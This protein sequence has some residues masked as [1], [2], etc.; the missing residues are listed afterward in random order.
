[1][2]FLNPFLY[3][4]S[5]SFTTDI[6]TGN[7]RCLEQSGCSCCSEGYYAS[8]GWDPVSG[9]GLV[10]FQ[11]FSAKALLVE[12][13]YPSQSPTLRPTFS[14]T[15]TPTLSPTYTPGAPTPIPTSAPSSAPTLLPT[16]N[17][18]QN[19]T[20]ETFQYALI[21]Q[22][23]DETCY[24]DVE[25]QTGYIANACIPDGNSSFILSCTPQDISFQ[26][27]ESS[28]D[29]TGVS[30]SGTIP[31]SNCLKG[32]NAWFCKNVESYYDLILMNSGNL[33]VTTTT[34]VTNTNTNL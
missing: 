17:P 11:L 27:Y 21:N 6:T 31:T 24:G 16:P 23:T 9:L 1:M 15:T 5:S 32:N 25:S 18:T 28:T 33:N 14:P 2:G 22:Y 8:S 30:T 19:P 4:F 12:T 34:N 20:V 29:C 7:N 26:F 10:D 3:E 13:P